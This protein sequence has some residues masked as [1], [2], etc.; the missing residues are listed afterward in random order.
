MP[1]KIKSILVLIIAPLLSVVTAQDTS[2][3]ADPAGQP[4]VVRVGVVTYSDYDKTHAESQQ[5]FA[6]I[7]S[8]YNASSKGTKI[9]FRVTV[10]AYDD[11]LEWYKTGLVDVAVLS[12]GPVAELLSSV[13]GESDLKELYIATAALPKA[14]RSMLA[15]PER[16]APGPHVKYQSVCVV[17]KDSPIRDWE[18]IEAG[19]R[20]KMVKF[21]FVHPL[22]ASGRILPEYVLRYKKGFDSDMLSK[23]LVEAE[24]TYDHSS[25]LKALSQHGGEGESKVAFVWDGI[26]VDPTKFRKIA[27][28]ELEEFWIP[29]EVVLVS[30]NF[31]ARKG[32]MKDVFLRYVDKGQGRGYVEV[33]DW[34]E[35]YKASIVEWLNKLELKPSKMGQQHF[36]LE[37]IIGKLHSYEL[38]RPGATRLALVLSGG[39]AK[40]AYQAG[41]IEAIEAELNRLEEEDALAPESVAETEEGAAGE[42]RRR[43]DIG[44]VVGTSGGAINALSTAL[45]VT[46]T[47]E[48]RAELQKTWLSFSQRDFFR[49]WSPMPFTLGLIVAFMQALVIILVLRLVDNEQIKWHR[50]TRPFILMLAVVA[51]A[52]FFSRLRF[53]ALIPL[54]LMAVIIGAQLFESRAS[55][56]RM[57]TGGTLLVVGIGELLV[58]HFSLTPWQRMQLVLPA[59]GFLVSCVAAILVIRLFFDQEMRWVRV[60]GVVIPVL[61]AAEIAFLALTW[62]ASSNRM[63]LIA[64]NHVVH[65]VWLF[66]TMNLVLTASCLI[67]IGVLMLLAELAVRA[68]Q[69]QGPGWV[70]RL[71]ARRGRPADGGDEGPEGV[72]AREAARGGVA[73]FKDAVLSLTQADRLFFNSRTPILRVLA[74]AL[75]SLLVFQVAGSLFYNTSLSDSGGLEHAFVSKLPNLLDH[76]PGV[77]VPFVPQG[78]DDRA[79][80]EDISRRIVG[81][82]LLQRDLVVT[83]SLLTTGDEPPDTYFYFDHRGPG[84][85]A[86]LPPDK[87]VPPDMRFKSFGDA[88]FAPRLLDVVIGSASIYPVFDPRCLPTSGGNCVPDGGGM[89]LIDGGFAHN[90]PIEAAIAW[91]ATHIILIEASPKAKPARG[92]NLWDNSL[93]AFNYLFSQA[94]L[95]DTHSKGKVELFSLRPGPDNLAEEPNLCTFDFVDFLVEGA[96]SKGMDDASEVENPKFLRGRGQPSF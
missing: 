80:L 70:V 77:E 16:R 75:A 71:W 95:L 94:Q 66:L 74:V 62:G 59:L 32:L 28:P 21:L 87:G 11:I 17:G 5:K 3:Q 96:I 29:Q 82:G 72:N 8:Q 1:H 24:W 47:D 92:S 76:H 49:P 64:W 65:H 4:V 79:R 91:G 37:Q 86:K 88:E 73:G 68:E 46:R 9:D 89:Q 31:A 44:L 20:E 67:A 93:D 7:A 18:D 39:G 57:T 10:G 78:E 23:N 60:A 22:S 14:T 61:A 42:K 34:V 56:W 43:L 69:G 52:L 53:W 63:R 35:Q 55:N 83:G 27:I 54:L 38:S 40:C 19:A 12:A 84:S 48:G 25:T 58:W 13:K 85:D 81:G 33:P 6:K 15:S 90:S 30:S 26:D 50:L 2:A 41:A 51:V 45:G 36:T